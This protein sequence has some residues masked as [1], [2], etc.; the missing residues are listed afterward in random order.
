MYKRLLTL[1]LFGDRI[2][3]PLGAK[4]DREKHAA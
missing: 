4:T 3:L 2:M 1:E